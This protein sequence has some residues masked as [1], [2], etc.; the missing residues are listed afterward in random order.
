MAMEHLPQKLTVHRVKVLERMV[1][2]KP[3]SA[4]VLLKRIRYVGLRWRFIYILTTCCV[5]HRTKTE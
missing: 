1:C 5:Q 4:K 2:C 3:E